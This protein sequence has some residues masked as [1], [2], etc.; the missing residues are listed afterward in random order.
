MTEKEILIEKFYQLLNSSSTSENDIQTFLETNSSLIPLP[1]ILN[2]AL[3]GNSVIS[4]L[5]LGNTYVTDFA[6]LTKSTVKWQLVLI[7]LEESKKKF[8]TKENLFS[9]EFNRALAQ[10]DDWKIYCDKYKDR[11]MKQTN[12]VDSRTEGT[13]FPRVVSKPFFDHVLASVMKIKA[14]P[15]N[16][17][18]KVQ[19]YS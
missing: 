15:L 1:F 6:Y 2:H 5:N 18:T 7:E 4:K 3:N 12:A 13:V 19:V 9:A 17:D 10:I 8:F 16:S 14:S 11:I